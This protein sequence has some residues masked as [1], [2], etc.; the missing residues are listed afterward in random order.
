ME[1]RHEYAEAAKLYKL[2]FEDA[3]NKAP[4]LTAYTIGI[5]YADHLGREDDAVYWL[6]KASGIVKAQQPESF[7]E[8]PLWPDLEKGLAKVTRPSPSDDAEYQRIA[9]EARRLIGEEKL[10]DAH[11]ILKDAARRYPAK[12]EMRFLVG[13]TLARMG[14]T[15]LAV[16][17]YKEAV[18][19]DPEN[20]RALFNLGGAQYRQRHF[21]EAR[22]TLRRYA[23]LAA[24]DQAEEEFLG[25]AEEL[26]GD[27]ARELKPDIE[28]VVLN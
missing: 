9:D 21:V 23:A 2:V 8:H 24:G 18:A 16:E 19:I 28:K 7:R 11:A 17:E 4:A 5:L 25:Q 3:R 14:K 6:R 22:D 12:A 1:R 10:D 13:L 27:I 15:A 20:R 26:L